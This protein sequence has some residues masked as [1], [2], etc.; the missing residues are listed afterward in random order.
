M[1][2]TERLRD[3][4][5]EIYTLKENTIK[6]LE[7]C[8]RHY[9]ILRVSSTYDRDDGIHPYEEPGRSLHKDV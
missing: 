6:S 3:L 1:K 4:R 9:S 7:Q 2:H 5:E 8:D